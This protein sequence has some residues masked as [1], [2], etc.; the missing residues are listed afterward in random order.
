MLFGEPQLFDGFFHVHQRRQANPAQP[1]VGLGAAVGEPAVVAAPKRQ[2]NF[3]ALGR[4]HQKQCRIKD[5]CFGAHLV[6][7]AQAFCHVQQLTRLYGGAGIVIVADKAHLP[8]TVDE[9]I[10]RRVFFR[11]DA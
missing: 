2:G 1:A 11:I 5:L 8:M 6:H 3:R 7:V 4:F 9:P 10:T